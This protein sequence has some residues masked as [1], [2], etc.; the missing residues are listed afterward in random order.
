MFY[1]SFASASLTHLVWLRR[2]INELLGLKG[3][4]KKFPYSG[5]YKLNYAKKEGMVV[6]K[7]MYLN[8]QDLRLERKYKKVYTALAIDKKSL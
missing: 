8:S 4:L 7:K 3:E 2:K 1:V 6:I 5:V